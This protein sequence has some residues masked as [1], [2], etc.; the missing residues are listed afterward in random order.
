MKTLVAHCGLGDS[1]ILSGAAVVLA[2]RYGG[3]RFPCYRQYLESVQSF[4]VNHP[5]IYVYPVDSDGGPWGV[6]PLHMFEIVGDP[7]LCGFYKENARDDISFIE[8]F[9]QQL[10]VDLNERWNSCP[11][12]EAASRFKIPDIEN[13]SW[14]FCL[15]HEDKARGFVIDQA[16][17]PR[18]MMQYHPIPGMDYEPRRSILRHAS[19]IQNVE[20]MDLIDSCFFHLAESLDV[21]GQLFLHRYARW[22]PGRWMDYPTKHKWEILT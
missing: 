7:I 15:V 9:Y 13:F 17:M 5:E 20:R 3:L 19:I 1:I 10:D 12:S 21:K 18:K 14:H 4:F 22:F 2:K 8:A 16:R 6:P 11:I